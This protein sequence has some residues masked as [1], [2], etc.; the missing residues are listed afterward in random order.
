[1]NVLLTGSTGYIG[2]KLKERLL[3]DTA[4][5]LRLFVRDIKRVDNKDKERV[6]IFEGDTFD[7]KSLQK[8]LYNIDVAYYLIHS[9]AAKGDYE[10]LDRLSAEN[11]L[12]ACIEAKVQKI[13]YLGGLGKRGTASKHLLSRIET[14]EILSSLPESIQTIWFRA[15]VIIGTGSASFEIIHNLVKKLPVMITPKWVHTK[16]QPIG[17]SSVLEYLF[18]AKDLEAK[19][20]LTVD[21]GSEAMSFK[22]M[23]IRAARVMGLR[24]RLI[25][26]PLLTPK[27]SSYWLRLVTSVPYRIA[28]E[29]IEG[30]KSETVI[31]N[32]NAV[33]YFPAVSPLSYEDAVQSALIGDRP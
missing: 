5:H 14:G 23:L 7:Y 26:V 21:I 11:F 18:Y 1:M 19:E 12:R 30:L 8:A 9:M 25:I 2:K 33:R 22:H 27:L 6:E 16:T 15:G 3:A 32:D 10:K 13:I 17:I 4:V 20:N 24:R 28:K 29:L 31:E